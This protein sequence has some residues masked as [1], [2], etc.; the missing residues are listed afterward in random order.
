MPKRMGSERAIALSIVSK[1]SG[2]FKFIFHQDFYFLKIIIRAI[3]IKGHFAHNDSC[4][5]CP[6][7]YYSAVS[8]AQQCSKCPEGRS[9][10]AVGTGREEDCLGKLL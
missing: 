5:P 8:G 10:Q 4:E 7:G 6:R 9:T 2:T 3:F 1:G